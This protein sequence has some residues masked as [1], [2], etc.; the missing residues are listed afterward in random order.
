[1]DGTQDVAGRTVGLYLS[2]DKTGKNGL[3]K[4]PGFFAWN[5]QIHSAHR[6]GRIGKTGPGAQNPWRRGVQSGS[7]R[8]NSA[9]DGAG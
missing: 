2:D 1:M 4:R 5:Q 9:G 7:S 8:A 3:C 6:S